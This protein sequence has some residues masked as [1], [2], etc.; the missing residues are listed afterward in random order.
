MPFLELKVTRW[1]VPDHTD[2]RAYLMDKV[3][4]EKIKVRQAA[5]G[6]VVWSPTPIFEKLEGGLV[7]KW[8][9][10]HFKKT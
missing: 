3:R 8:R 10:K 2:L 6:G 7:L 4:D 9:Y 1:E 5:T